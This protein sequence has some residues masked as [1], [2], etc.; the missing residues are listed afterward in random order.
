MLRAL[1]ITR[2]SERRRSGRPGVEAPEAPG[3]ESTGEKELTAE[4]KLEA[5]LRRSERNRDWHKLRSRARQREI[6]RL[7]KRLAE[8][9]KQQPGAPGSPVAVDPDEG[10]EGPYVPTPEDRAESAAEAK[11]FGQ[12]LLLGTGADPSLM[13]ANETLMPSGVVQHATE[14]LELGVE[15]PANLAGGTVVKTLVE[16]RTRYDFSLVVTRVE[17]AVE[18]KVVVTNG[19]RHVISASTSAFGPAGWGVTWNAMS[20]LA[21]LVSQFALPFNRLGVMF[22]TP[23]KRFNS[24]TLSRMFLAVARWLVPIYLQLGKNLAKSTVLSGDDTRARVL[25]VTGYFDKLKEEHPTDKRIKVPDPPWAPYRNVAAAEAA[26]KACAEIKRARTK[27]R[28]DGDREAKPTAAEVPSLG[29]LIGREF[30]F[31]AARRNGEG[32]K[33]SLNVSVISGRVDKEDPRSLIVFYRSHLGSYGN[34]LEYVLRHRDSKDGTLRNLVTQG[35]LS[36]TNLVVDAD[37]LRKFAIS[38]IGCSAHARRPFAN[39]E[40]EAP[41]YCGYLLHLFGGLA[42]IEQRLDVHGRNKENVLAVRGHEGR[43][44]WGEIL[45]LAKEMEGDWPSTSKLGAAARYVINHYAKLT[46]Y[47]DD[48]YLEPSNNLRERMLRLEKLI[49]RASMFRKSLEGRFA[50]DVVRTVV[51][52]AVAGN[53]PVQEYLEWVLS[54]EPAEVAE[55]PSQFTPHAWARSRAADNPQPAPPLARS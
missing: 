18:K 29:V 9:R 17:L 42:M 53:V 43:E 35:D 14:R 39:Y 38:T 45:A 7:K 16:E 34:A 8:M 46:A 12:R 20:T 36:T 19:E 11:A 51:Q 54:A 23:E 5:A 49:E 2:S 13:S 15:I 1:H 25:E 27:R 31:E 40:H 30:P 6:T 4:E 41:E 21:V 52:T 28:R 22:S 3:G 50:L 48:P 37:L 55:S 47:L 24:A 26:L 32:F 10:D 44:Y 33:S